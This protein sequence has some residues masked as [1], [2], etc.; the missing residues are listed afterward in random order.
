MARAKVA[1]TAPTT[2]EE[3]RF[4]TRIIQSDQSDEGAPHAFQGSQA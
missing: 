2:L 4:K 1:T 3:S